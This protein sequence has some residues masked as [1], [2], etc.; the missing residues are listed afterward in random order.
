MKTGIDAKD[1][2]DLISKSD[3]KPV[4]AE[5]QKLVEVVKDL[6]KLMQLTPGPKSNQNQGP[7]DLTNL[8]SNGEITEK[9]AYMWSAPAE[10]FRFTLVVS[11]LVSIGVML[12]SSLFS[13]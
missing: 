3:L 1:D 6:H 10:K 7:S 8:S 5:G 12:A 11:E 9:E 2:K 13:Y 4:E